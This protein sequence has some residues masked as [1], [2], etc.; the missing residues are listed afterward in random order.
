MTCRQA[1]KNHADVH[2]TVNAS[3]KDNIGVLYGH[4]IARE[5]LPLEHSTE[6]GGGFKVEG[7]LTNGNFS[8]KRSTLV[9]FINNRLVESASIKKLVDTVY[10]PL[11]PKGGHPWVY[12]SLMLPPENLDVNVHPTKKEVHFLHE[13]EILEELSQVGP[14]GFFL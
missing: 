3:R 10:A 7:F 4:N 1:G 6:V 11:L 13:D 14:F 12:L 9:L 2:T 5:L 8:S